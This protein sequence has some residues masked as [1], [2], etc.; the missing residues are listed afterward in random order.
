MKRCVFILP[1]FGPLRNYFGLFLKTCANNKEYDWL[2]ITDQDI[3]SPPQNVRVL[4]MDFKD[5]CD[6]V[7]SRFEFR[8]AL[9]KP[10]KICDFKPTLG[11]VFE[12]E[13]DGYEYWGHCDCDLLFG[14]LH[15]ILE[16]LFDEG[17]EKIF[18]AGHMTIY[19]NTFEVNRLFMSKDR[20]GFS[21]HLVALSKE[22]VFAFDEQLFSRNVHTLFL[23]NCAKVYEEDLAFNASM[24][25]FG[26]RREALNPS[27]RKWEID[28]IKPSAVWLDVNGV[29]A[30][31]DT[32][33]F[34][35]VE[36]YTYIHLQGRVMELPD[37]G[38]MGEY[39]QVLPDRFVGVEPPETGSEIPSGLH[40]HASWPKAALQTLRRTKHRLFDGD[41]NPSEFD[42]YAP[43]L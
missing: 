23:D 6:F 40:R 7:Q 10:Y 28:K 27:N 2:I 33:G 35:E 12:N 39:V 16:P 37:S 34:Q 22:G 5:F 3:P 31:F 43:Y 13:I 17:Y 41:N 42:P 20:N 29:A 30:F 38:N 26:L 4:S 11:Y 14:R 32:A 24:N 21:M 9:D 36:R 25:Y 15:P 1:W 19:R 18:G 8:I